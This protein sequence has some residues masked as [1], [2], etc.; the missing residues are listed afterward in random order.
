MSGEGP[1]FRDEEQ[2]HRQAGPGMGRVENGSDVQRQQTAGGRSYASS[3]ESPRQMS[4]E[5]RVRCC[6]TCA[7][8]VTANGT[9][10][11]AKITDP[12]SGQTYGG[13]PGHPRQYQLAREAR[14]T[15][16]PLTDCGPG[17]R[18]WE[19]IF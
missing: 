17:A 7:R 12:V 14:M 18:L 11:I 15:P 10:A 19:A 5:H 4:D 2:L 6:A 9:C 8:F 16:Y 1:R 13:E 3:G